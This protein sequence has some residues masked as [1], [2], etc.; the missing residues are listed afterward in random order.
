[1]E[2][3]TKYAYIRK[4]IST[5]PKFISNNFIKKIVEYIKRQKRKK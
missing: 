1:M 2:K 5:D 4:S 3:D